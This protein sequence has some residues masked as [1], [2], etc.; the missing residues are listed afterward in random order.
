MAEDSGATYVFRRDAGGADN[1]GQVAK[2][3]ADDA[4]FVAL[5]GSAVAVN[6]DD[7]TGDGEVNVLDLLSILAAWG[8]CGGC[9]EDLNHDGAVDIL[10]LLVVLTAWS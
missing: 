4:T 3:K 9:P 1:W 7:V 8:S 5:F 6:G 2:L 10:D